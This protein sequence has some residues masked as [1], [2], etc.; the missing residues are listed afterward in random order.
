MGRSNEHK[1]FQRGNANGQQAH[2]KMLNIT[3]VKT[4]Q[5][6]TIPGEIYHLTSARMAIIKK[7]KKKSKLVQSLW[8]TV[9]KFLK[10]LKNRTTIWPSNSTPGYVS[11]ENKSS[12]SKRHTPIFIAALFTNCQDME[13]T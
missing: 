4:M 7:K 3:K 8:K 10:I 6:K 1:F 11:K 9:W 13:A 5:V 2:E 12:D